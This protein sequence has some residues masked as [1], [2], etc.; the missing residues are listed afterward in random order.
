MVTKIFFIP[1][2]S[3]IPPWGHN[4]RIYDRDYKKRDLYEKIGVMTLNEAYD[5][6]LLQSGP[7]NFSGHR[8]L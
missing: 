3:I 4:L 5:L 7:Y 1:Q 2:E 8:Y 6:A